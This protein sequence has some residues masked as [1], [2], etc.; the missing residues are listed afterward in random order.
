MHNIISLA[1]EIMHNL[2]LFE[3][4]GRI[5]VR[6]KK[7]WLNKY[8]FILLTLFIFLST[9]VPSAVIIRNRQKGST[10]VQGTHYPQN[11]SA[12]NSGSNPDS[13]EYDNS[14]GRTESVP[15]ISP[16]ASPVQISPSQKSN[17][18]A[19]QAD[20]GSESYEDF[21]KDSLFIGDSISEGLSS[22]GFLD[23]SC[24][25]AH[26]G[27]TVQKALN[28]V[29][30][31]LKG[32]PDNI[33]ILLGSNDILNGVKPEK[34]AADYLS[35]IQHIR[36]KMPGSN[37]YVQSIFPVSVKVEQQKPPLSNS[38]INGFN[39]ALREMAD[40]AGICYLDTASVF[41]D[42][43]GN[44]AEEYSSDGIH[45]KYEAYKLWLDYLKC[46]IK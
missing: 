36:E 1:L 17:P 2:L 31:I 43:N 26:K 16:D 19:I 33:F 20:K 13:L 22:Y 14:A 35:L 9:V 34:F 42:D 29:T 4:R 8:L 11:D 28:E 38:A 40:N 30:D 44:M 21:F 5:S 18:E 45:I 27:M 15:D 41:Y 7:I 39:A 3:E 46:N 32:K 24:L 23:E 6:Y 12:V 37:I 10:P 25:S